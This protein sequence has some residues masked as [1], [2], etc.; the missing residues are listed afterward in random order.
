MTPIDRSK[1]QSVNV[2][3][4]GATGAVGR[5]ILACLKS[6]KFPFN[7]IFLFA[8]SKSV[9]ES[10]EEFS[11]NAVVVKDIKIVFLAVNSE[12]SIEFAP[13][14]AQKKIHV[15]DN[16]CAF[17]NKPEIPLIVPELNPEVIIETKHGGGGIIANP[18]CTT[19]ILAMAL[20]P[21]HKKF[22]LKK[23]ICS[24]YQAASGA[25]DPGMQE[26]LS[27]LKS[28]VEGREFSPS[29]FTPHDISCNVIPSIDAANLSSHE[30]T[31]EELKMVFETRKI[32]DSYDIDISCT[33]VRVPTMRAHCVSAS[34]EFASP[35]S[36]EEVVNILRS[37]PG[38]VLTDIPTPENAS[39]LSE[40][41]VGRIR[42]SL[43]FKNKGI[44]MFV[45]GDQLLRGA[46]LNAVRIAFLLID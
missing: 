28:R 4:V 24:T 11:V 39:N 38:V 29:V 21:L 13:Q 23:L 36:V 42:Q 34:A 18:N 2:G 41:L 33:A 9:S 44:D 43:V 35:I 5:E 45:A 3:I 7:N 22:H 30:Y 27:A 14:L 20:F 40:I 8:S 12:F 1:R 37:A 19:A 26:L 16:S 46:A 6:E 17:R 10:V 25:G 31:R 15:I 32:F